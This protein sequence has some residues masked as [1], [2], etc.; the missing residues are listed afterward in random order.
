MQGEGGDDD[1]NILYEVFKERPKRECHESDWEKQ[2]KR[3]VNRVMRA[4]DLRE[5]EAMDRIV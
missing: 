4:L 1:K 3:C 2:Y 5:N